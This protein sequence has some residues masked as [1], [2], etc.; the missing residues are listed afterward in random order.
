MVGFGTV[1]SRVVRH[2]PRRGVL[3]ASDHM[4]EGWN[5]GC[6][7]GGGH[8]WRVQGPLSWM[9][10]ADLGAPALPPEA[11]CCLSLVPKSQWKP[12]CSGGWGA[13][14]SQHSA[15]LLMQLLGILEGW[16][17]YSVRPTCPFPVS[18]SSVVQTAAQSTCELLTL[19]DPPGIPALWGA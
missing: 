6:K 19:L 7:S 5:P 4:Q 14:H 9:V 2:S 1:C 13:D 15:C 8:S 18:S 11:F 3:H 10:T 16:P 12:I 17:S